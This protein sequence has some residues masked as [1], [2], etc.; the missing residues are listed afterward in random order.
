MAIATDFFDA[1]DR[2]KAFSCAL[3]ANS[4]RWHHNKTAI[5]KSFLQIPQRSSFQ[6]IHCSAF[7]ASYSMENIAAGLARLG[8][9][10]LPAIPSAHPDQNPLDIFRAHIAERLAPLANVDE[11]T[12]FAGLDRATK[13]DSGDFI[14]AVPRLRIKGAKPDV[15]GKKWQAEVHPDEFDSHVLTF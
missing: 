10:S 2:R 13:P 11:V 8:V 14:L 6:L 3:Y 15:L 7:R 5:C 12:V 9:E 1:S 4:P